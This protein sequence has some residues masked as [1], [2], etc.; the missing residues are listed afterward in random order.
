MSLEVTQEAKDHIIKIGYDVAYGARPLRRVIQNMVE[1]VLAEQLLLS[2]YKPGTTIV[3][4]KGE[5]AGLSIHEADEKSPPPSKPASAGRSARDPHPES[6]R[7]PG[8]RRV[9]P[10][11]GGPVSLVRR[12]EHARGDARPRGLARRAPTC[13]TGRRQRSRFARRA[14]RD[15]RRPHP[16]RHR[17][18]RP[19]ARRWACA[20]LAGAG[21]GRAGDRQ[22]NAPPAGRSRPLRGRPGPV[23]DRRGVECAGPPSGRAPWPSRRR[24]R[25]VGDGL[26]GE[27]RGP[28]PR[29]GAR[30][31]TDRAHRRLDPDRD[32]GRA[33]RAGR[34]RRPGARVGPAIHGARQ[35]GRDRGDPRS[36]T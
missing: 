22:I 23:C 11:L 34:Q 17:R 4:D 25:S 10:P 2:R 31:E 24:S 26:P 19:G 16:G 8:L 35:G 6:L 13:R 20:R 1:D 14:Q 36:V 18:A 9:V 12:L 27:L 21:R 5:E 7:L 3:V 29:D 33:G 32:G 30:R 28:D 15:R